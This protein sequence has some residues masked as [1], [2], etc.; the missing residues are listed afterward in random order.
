IRDLIVTGVQ[1]CALPIFERL[2]SPQA[3]A[4]L[5]RAHLSAARGAA[6]QAS[7][8]TKNIGQ[9]PKDAFVSPVRTSTGLLI[10]SEP[11]LGSK[12]MVEIGRASCR[13]RGEKWVGG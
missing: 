2:H 7:A 4:P 6:K 5:V 11:R 1:T 8:K 10:A 12:H 3:R 9:P 13:E